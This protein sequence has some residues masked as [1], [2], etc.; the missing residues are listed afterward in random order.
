V[1]KEYFTF[2]LFYAVYDHILFAGFNIVNFSELK[3]SFFK[4]F[5]IMIL[6]RPY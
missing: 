5:V 3:T 4:E 2:L 1:K 6:G